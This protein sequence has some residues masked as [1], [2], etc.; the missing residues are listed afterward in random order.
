[1]YSK[2]SDPESFDRTGLCSAKRSHP[3]AHHKAALALFF[4]HYNYVQ[5]H[6]TLMTPA[7]KA[8]LVDHQWTVAEI[9]ER[10]A[11]CR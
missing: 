1:L 6:G 3:A 2:Y 10:T 8:G 11:N 7:V 4:M 5:R 9:I